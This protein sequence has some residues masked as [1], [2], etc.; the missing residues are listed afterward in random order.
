MSTSST[1]RVVRFDAPQG[2]VTRTNANPVR[3]NN[4]AIEREARRRIDEA[5]AKLDAQKAAAAQ[6]SS[7]A[8]STTAHHDEGDNLSPAAALAA[9]SHGAFE[10]RHQGDAHTDGG[11]LSP[12]DALN[13]RTAGAFER[14]G[15]RQ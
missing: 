12:A 2:P 6:S 5:R 10:A 11:D 4:A 8:S 1:G 9:R 7:R 14:N 15:S 3:P 13:A